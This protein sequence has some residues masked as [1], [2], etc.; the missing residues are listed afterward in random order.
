LLE[1]NFS[2]AG[3]PRIPP[4]SGGIQVN[5]CKKPTCPNFGV[6]AAQQT[7]R[8]RSAAPRDGYALTSAGRNFPVLKCHGCGEHPPLKSNQGIHEERTRLSAYLVSPP[9]VTCPNPACQN[10][11]TALQQ[12][13][14]QYQAFGK[15]KGGSQRYRC[16]ACGKTF[17]VGLATVRQKQPHKNRLVFQLLMNK[18]PFRRVCEVAGISPS[19]LYGK[20]HFLHQQCLAFVREREQRLLQGLAI[21]RLYVGVDRQIYVVNWTQREDKRNV[22]LA[23]VGSADN[24]TGY[25]FGMDLNFDA[26]LDS[27]EGEGQAIARG[28]YHRPYPFRRHARLWLDGDYEHAVLSRRGQA[29]LLHDNALHGAVATRYAEAEAREDVEAFEAPSGT[30]RLPAKGMQVHAEYT[31]YGH[32]FLLREL[33]RGV[34]KVR[35]FLD[36]DSGMRAACLGAFQPR[37]QSRQCDA[38]YVRVNK[39]LTVDER[40][41]ALAES[42]AK[43]RHTGQRHPGLTDSELKLLLIKE[44]IR[45]M[46][47]IGKWQDRWLIHPFPNMSEPEKAACYLTDYGDYDQDHLAWLYNKASLHAINRFFM[48]VRRRLSILERPILSASAARRMWFGYSAYNPETIVKLLGIFRVY[49]NYVLVAKDGQTPAMRLGLAKEK[50]SPE[51]I[52]Y[53]T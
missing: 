39:E 46:V 17:A 1:K 13:R 42:R 37:I 38:F 12:G 31:L 9:A 34:E 36:Q 47:S 19:T 25:V 18:E 11:D 22:Q 52:I 40:R 7:A 16:K 30:T 21:R 20:L 24:A 14:A 27:D 53:Y 23:A 5:F 10:H 41:R 3:R 48:Q 2:E 51:D 49:Y 44:R 43:F 26:V 6:P 4:E 8:G 29:P 45:S 32:F 50:V 15:T 33:F 28:D 35:F